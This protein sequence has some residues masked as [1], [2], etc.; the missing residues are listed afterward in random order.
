MEKKIKVGDV[1]KVIE[2]GARYAN[3]VPWANKHKLERFCS[4]LDP[5]VHNENFTVVA[6][7]PHLN[8]FENHKTLYGIQDSRGHQFII[9]AYGVEL[10]PSKKIEVGLTLYRLGLQRPYKKGELVPVKV[11]KVGRKYFTAKEDSCNY[12]I[13]YHLDDLSEKTE[14]DVTTKLYWSEQECLDDKERNALLDAIKKYFRDF[15]IT[16]SLQQL[17]EI[18]KVLML[19][20]EADAKIENLNS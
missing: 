5:L 13:Q 19:E 11:T 18:N 9:G 20:V 14:Y 8:D 7:G 17:R 12:D 4:V 2:I 3:Y 6:I 1:V 10:A 16:L 15:N